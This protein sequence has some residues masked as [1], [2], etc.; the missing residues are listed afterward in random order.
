M[1]KPIQCLGGAV[2]LVVILTAR[3]PEQLVKIAREPSRLTRQEHLSGFEHDAPRLHPRELFDLRTNQPRFALGRR[4]LEILRNTTAEVRILDQRQI[5]PPRGMHL[6]N[7]V[8]K[9]RHL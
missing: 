3:K 4:T 7:P 9:I 8:T 2:D 1:L 6:L 5:R